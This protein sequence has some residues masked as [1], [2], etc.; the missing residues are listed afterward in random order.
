M[1]IGRAMQAIR[2]ERGLSRKDVA[3]M[4]GCTAN[5]IWKIENGKTQPKP[6]TVQLFCEYLETPIARLY[7][8]ALE[9]ADFR[10]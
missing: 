6:K 2:E 10:V 5:S 3:T 8:L 9:D 1:N 4:L 7:T